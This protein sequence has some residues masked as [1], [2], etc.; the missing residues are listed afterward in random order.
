MSAI[1]FE[2]EVNARAIGSWI[3][4]RGRFPEPVTQRELL[5]SAQQLGF[6]V[7][8]LWAANLDTYGANY[9]ASSVVSGLKETAGSITGQLRVHET[10]FAQVCEQLLSDRVF[11]H[12]DLHSRPDS[13][14]FASLRLDDPAHRK[15]V[16]GFLKGILLHHGM[17][18]ERDANTRSLIQQYARAGGLQR[19]VTQTFDLFDVEY[20]HIHLSD[21]MEVVRIWKWA[22]EDAGQIPKEV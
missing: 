14:D 20:A 1:P 19:L 3:D 17:F 9:G 6:E 7:G 18:N 4:A 15:F 8:S 13:Y 16:S 11:A 21:M 10:G 2:A 5:V 12:D 22:N